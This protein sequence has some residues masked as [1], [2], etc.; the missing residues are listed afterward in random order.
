FLLLVYHKYRQARGAV[1]G[2]GRVCPLRLPTNTRPPARLPEAAPRIAGLVALSHHRRPAIAH[3]YRRAHIA[4]PDGAVVEL[5]GH[6]V[7]RIDRADVPVVGPDPAVRR[8]GVGPGARGLAEFVDQTDVR[9]VL[10]DDGRCGGGR[11]AFFDASPGA[12]Q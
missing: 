9:S 2:R 1:S 4:L 6:A 12:R 11:P 8:E 7:G 10:R 5:E 3:A